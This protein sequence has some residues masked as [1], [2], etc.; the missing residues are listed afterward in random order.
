M[1]MRYVRLEQLVV[2]GE[3]SNYSVMDTT[4]SVE[5]VSSLFQS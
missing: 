1:G 2:S 5:D 3:L 4:R